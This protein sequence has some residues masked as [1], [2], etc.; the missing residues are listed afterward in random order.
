MCA[1]QGMPYH[2]RFEVLTDG[3]WACA[4]D[5]KGT[6]YR[7]DGLCFSRRRRRDHSFALVPSWQTPSYGWL[8]PAECPCAVWISAPPAPLPTMAPAYSRDWAA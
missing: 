5:T 8:H 7:F 3:E 4:A 1:A 6:L 2:S